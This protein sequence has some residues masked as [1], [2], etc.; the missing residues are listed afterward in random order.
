VPLVVPLAAASSPR[1]FLSSS[2]SSST[3]LL[4]CLSPNC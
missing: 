4:Q 3:W 2:R 1:V